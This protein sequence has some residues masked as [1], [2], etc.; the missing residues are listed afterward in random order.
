M[1]AA[2]PVVLLDPHPRTAAMI[3]CAADRLRLDTLAEV[4]EV[5]GGPVPAELVDACLP[6]VTAILGQTA[7]PAQRLSRALQL[8]AVF[9]VEGNFFANIDYPACFARGIRVA[10]AA[11]AFARPV[12]EYALALLL[13]LARGVTGADRA[14]RRGQEQYGWRGNDDI[15]SLFGADVGLVGFGN[16]ARALV[17][18]LRPFGCTVRA[19]DP[20][21]PD[22]VLRD[23]G[24]VPAGLDPLLAL[25]RLVV[26]LA[27]PTAQNA[28]CIGAPELARMQRGAGLV[29]LSRAEV[30]DYAALQTSLE[31][32]HIR[33]AIDVFPQEPLAPD[34]PLRRCESAV[35][36]SHRA[37]GLRSAL[38]SI[39]QMAL[40]DLELVLRGLP[41]VRMQLAQP[42]TVGLQRS[43]PGMR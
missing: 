43:T 12:A 34:H 21:L 15:E 41:P 32:G 28:H 20:W 8:R 14:F 27:A 1:S 9:N 3:F 10:C 42:E 24:V 30:V 6:R 7:L 39:G 5:D 19:F 38:F 4:I 17:P 35:L 13:D 23:H 18:L 2:K 25:S 29:L 36:S 16:T 11:P 26:V 31:A 40:D 22:A 33:A 37:G